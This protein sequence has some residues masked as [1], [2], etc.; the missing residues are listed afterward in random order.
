MASQVP[1]RTK[2][3]ERH[4][5][6][7]KQ[8]ERH[9]MDIER[10]MEQELYAYLKYAVNTI[11]EGSILTHRQRIDFVRGWMRSWLGDDKLRKRIPRKKLL[12]KNKR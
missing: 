2:Q 5:L 6:D 7:K 10:Y 8:A 11:I 4:Y 12:G 3:I 1:K 9:C